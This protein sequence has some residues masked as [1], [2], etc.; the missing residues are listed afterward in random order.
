MGAY[1]GP[2]RRPE[3]GEWKPL[4]IFNLRAHDFDPKVQPRSPL[5]TQSN[6]SEYSAN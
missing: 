2:V 1:V 3:K 5:G 4:K 6:R